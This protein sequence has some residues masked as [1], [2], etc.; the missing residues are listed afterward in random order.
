MTLVRGQLWNEGANKPPPPSSAYQYAI[1]G[2]HSS[3]LPQ[4]A[5]YKVVG[6]AQG[7]NSKDLAL[8]VIP[9]E[10]T[11]ERLLE[12]LGRHGHAKPREGVCN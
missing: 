11:L 3:V 12:I 4:G 7:G 1:S 8:R 5:E 6:R 9:G 2:S 10:K